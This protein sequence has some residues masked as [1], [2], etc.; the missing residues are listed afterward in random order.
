MTEDLLAVA[1][2]GTLDLIARQALVGRRELGLLDEPSALL[3]ARLLV[4]RCR[5][6]DPWV[7][8]G[9]GTLDRFAREVAL[10]DL[11]GLLAAGRA[12][13]A[14]AERSLQRIAWRHDGIAASQL[15]SLSF[16]PRLWWTAAGVPVSWRPLL[17]GAGTTGADPSGRAAAAD[18]AAGPLPGRRTDVDV[19][20]LLLA[21]IGTGAT[22]TELLGVRVRDAGR[23]DATGTLVADL[24]AE[25]LAVAYRGEDDGAE[26]VTFLSF[27]ARAAL[28]AQL[29]ARGRLAPEDPLLLPSDRAAPALHAARSMSSALIGA[30]N[31][32]NVTMCRAT[33]D[34]FRG[35]GMPGARFD[36]RTQ[37]FTQAP[38]RT[39][40]GR[41]TA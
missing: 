23:L 12:D 33:G 7:R 25:P 40:E 29:A 16:G 14:E 8:A 9:V 18:N 17:A 6:P 27:E 4:R 5:R 13:P 10:G 39:H 28:H 21:V 35:W 1:D 30:G 37:S 38:R 31:D 19:R 26:H 32:V 22:D 34:F 15:A 3:L 41:S 2:D 11:P 20:L 36:V 24:A